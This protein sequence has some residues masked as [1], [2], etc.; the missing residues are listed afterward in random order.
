MVSGSC[1]FY[2]FSETL[3]PEGSLVAKNCSK[4]KRGKKK[5]KREK[6]SIKTEKPK[7][8]GRFIVQKLKFL[9]CAHSPAKKVLRVIFVK[10][11]NSF[12]FQGLFLRDFFLAYNRP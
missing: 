6:K 7:V 2:A 11:K 10:S 4:K 12:S 8:V 1:L 9:I 5:V 3:P